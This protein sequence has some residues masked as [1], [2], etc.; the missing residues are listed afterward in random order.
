[1]T[2]RPKAIALWFAILAL[3]FINGVLREKALVPA[4]GSVGGLVTSGVILS[5]CIF[6]VAWAGAPWYG[7][8]KSHQWLLIGGLWLLLTLAFEFG[9]GQLVQH[10]TWAE[11]LE[12]YTF[13]G[14]NLWPLV[15]LVTCAAPWMA[16]KVRGLV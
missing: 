15:L 13:K 12:A 4:L 14:G 16:A 2:P 10:K 7:P 5:A 3:A 1:M 8:L 6:L 11:L 9:F